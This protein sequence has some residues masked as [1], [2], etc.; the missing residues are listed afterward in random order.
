MN[1]SDIRQA[2]FDQI[3]WQPDTSVD[4]VNRL[5]R[6]INR[7]YQQLS[8]EA[9]FLF[10]EDVVHFAT[11][12]DVES[13]SGI[14]TDRVAVNSADT[15]VL[16]RPLT[17]TD[18]S[19]W[20][21]DGTWDGRTIE[22]TDPSDQVHRRVIREVF[23]DVSAAVARVTLDRPW[24]NTVDVGMTYRI[25]SPRYFLPADVLEVQNI[26]LWSPLYRN[27]IVLKYRQEVQETWQDDMQGQNSAATPV[28]AFR[29]GHFQI[30]APTGAP[31]VSVLAESLPYAWVG[32]DPAGE[33]QYL[34]T[35]VR[36]Y[37]DREFIAPLGKQDPKWESAPSPNTSAVTATFGSGAIQIGL[38][39][40]SWM[41]GFGDSSTERYQHSGIRKRIYRRR[42]TSVG[43]AHPEVET[44]P[45][46][47]FLA[48]VSGDTTTYIDDGAVQVD[49][50]RRLKIVHGYQS[51]QMS[52]MPDARYDVDVRC[53]R[54]PAP[55]DQDTD[56]ARIHEEGIDVLIHK[57]LGL[58]Y[59]AMGN[60]DM[61]NQSK[62]TYI[63][64][65]VT[66]SKRY[67][68]LPHGRFTKKL[69]RAR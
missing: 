29:M 62:G 12:P 63:G 19:D 5:D 47:Y 46:Y 57:V 56:A 4:I 40:I 48:E 55:L 28:R 66:L 18:V 35:Y 58:I 32:P 50:K 69:A 53:V 8:L 27:P 51:I 52:P 20:V 11:E 16:E 41:L 37:R 3:D 34:F 36:G 31:S 22:V 67:G 2:V 39:D 68:S 42:N 13:V 44:P 64:Q 49:L 60:P 17:I 59:E 7:A 61:A 21:T 45:I 1:R 6:F 10:F 26:R 9:P 43:G 38:P 30:D 14:A 15:Y 25:T 23:A 24:R 54:R 33:F 65:L